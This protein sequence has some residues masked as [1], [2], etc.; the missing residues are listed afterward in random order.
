MAA[1]RSYRLDASAFDRERLAEAE[2]VGGRIG[3]TAVAA[4]KELMK[5]TRRRA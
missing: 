4:G 5:L 2:I 1:A 3:E